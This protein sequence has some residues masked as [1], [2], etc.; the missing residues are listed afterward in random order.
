MLVSDW[1][2]VLEWPKQFLKCGNQAERLESQ[3]AVPHGAEALSQSAPDGSNQA[4]KY[5][6]NNPKS[7]TL[8]CFNFQGCNV[9]ILYILYICHLNEWTFGTA[10]VSC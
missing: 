9:Y 5:G 4:T 6:I 1:S 10:A 3:T 8:D 7:I 2:A